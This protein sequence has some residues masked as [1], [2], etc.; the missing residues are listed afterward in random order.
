MKTYKIKFIT[1]CFCAGANQQTADVRPSS[2]RGELRWWFRCLGGTREGEDKVFG[3]LAGGGKAS[4]IVVR[5]ANV[6]RGQTPYTASFTSPGDPGAY[7]HY[8]LTAPNESGLSR[9]WETPPCPASKTKGTVREASQLP[10]GTAFDLSFLVRRR[11]SQELVDKLNLA[12]EMMLRFGGIGYRRTRGFGAWINEDSLLTRGDTEKCL[13]ALEVFGFT[14]NLAQG[15]SKDGLV[16][17]RQVENR[18]KGDREAN[19]GLRLHH[20]AKERTPLGYSL[21]RSARQTSAV[22]FR[23]TPFMTKAGEIQF[24]LLEL[25]APDSVLGEST[26]KERII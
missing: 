5:V 1:P 20:P 14:W 9:M 24:S 12:M 4:S 8:L 10:P 6:T 18:L 16:V 2:I 3:T 19:T 7:L 21:G 15:G 17:L 11:E 13:K 25:Q 22:L 23:P 26:K